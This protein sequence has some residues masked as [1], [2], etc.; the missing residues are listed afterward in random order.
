MRPKS[1]GNLDR[2]AVN[3]PR[4]L[5]IIHLQLA[6]T[7]VRTIAS[8]SAWAIRLDLIQSIDKP[9]AQLPA[10]MVQ[11]GEGSAFEG[12][13]D[14]GELTPTSGSQSS[15]QQTA[16]L[17][18][19]PNTTRIPVY[20][21]RLMADYARQLRRAQG[22]TGPDPGSSTITDGT[23]SSITMTASPSTSAISPPAVLS[24]SP[25]SYPSSVSTN[26]SPPGSSHLS[27]S[28]SATSAGATV[29][30]LVLPKPALDS[31]ANVA[32]AATQAGIASGAVVA[33]SAVPGNG[34]VPTASVMTYTPN[35]RL[36][37]VYSPPKQIAPEEDLLPPDNFAMVS[38]FI[39]RSS[40]PKK[41]NFPF[42]RSLGLKSV[43]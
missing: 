30:P 9:F 13:S 27:S 38:S 24:R 19:V 42:L 34:A 7:L 43:L 26:M 1:T 33:S 21:E 37:D 5:I 2:D 39:Y 41:K 32:A 6:S 12:G 36:E 8:I 15:D 28:S 3:S 35:R 23:R 18:P 16:N 40:F 20:L 11:D 31:I 22:D 17:D 29:L 10:H 4:R 25:S 14:G